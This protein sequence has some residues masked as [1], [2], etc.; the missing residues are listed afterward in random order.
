MSYHPTH[1]SA[2]VLE[3]VQTMLDIRSQWNDIQME[4]GSLPGPDAKA[5]GEAAQTSLN[6]IDLALNLIKYND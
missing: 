4:A 6:A 3:L 5:I 1:L 2:P